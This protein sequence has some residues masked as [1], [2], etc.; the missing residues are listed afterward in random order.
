LAGR[1]AFRRPPEQTELLGCRRAATKV[2]RPVAL[3]RCCSNRTRR[4]LAARGSPTAS[5]A[6]G[7]SGRPFLGFRRTRSEGFGGQTLINLGADRGEQDAAPT[8]KDVGGVGAS[9]IAIL[10]LWRSPPAPATRDQPEVCSGD[11]ASRIS[12]ADDL[13]P[14]VRKFQSVNLTYAFTAEVAGA[15]LSGASS[16]MH[17]WQM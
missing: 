2:L 10:G 5:T 7:S 13:G 11:A 17:P 9:W 6:R 16:R 4:A 15:L 1:A 3:K 8:I 14:G 12:K